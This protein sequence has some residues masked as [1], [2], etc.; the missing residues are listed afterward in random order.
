MGQLVTYI[1][2]EQ[3]EFKK[4]HMLDPIHQGTP[5]E[6]STYTCIHNKL[7]TIK[8]KIYILL[9]IRRLINKPR[10]IKKN[11]SKQKSPLM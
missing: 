3:E 10:T 4:S 6:T 7:T 9:Y 2:L 11:K 8:E 1:V 5:C